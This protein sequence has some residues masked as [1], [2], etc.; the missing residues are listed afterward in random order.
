MFSAV[1]VLFIVPWL[2]TSKVRSATFRPLYK[3]IFW[4]LVVDVVVLGWVGADRRRG[5]YVLIGRVATFYY[6]FHF[7]IVLPL[8]GIFERPLPLPTSIVAT[9]PVKGGARDAASAP[10]VERLTRQQG[11][12]GEI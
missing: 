6:F 5:I 7:L 8:L 12:H 2:D 1:G 10:M 9:I 11:D 3:W 4:V